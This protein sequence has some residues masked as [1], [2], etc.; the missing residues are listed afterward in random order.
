MISGSNRSIA[1]LIQKLT[2]VLSNID[3]S[4]NTGLSAQRK[5]WLQR[6]AGDLNANDQIC[7]DHGVVD[8]RERKAEALGPSSPH[9]HTSPSERGIGVGSADM[10]A[11]IRVA[12]QAL[13][14]CT[15][16]LSCYSGGTCIHSLATPVSE[17]E[18]YSC[19]SLSTDS[20]RSHLSSR[21]GPGG[22]RYA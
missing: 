1:E 4:E 13:H 3:I 20:C 18:C 15:A 11:L 22:R 10:K 5:R 14:S 2:R 12:F 17:F 16:N 8:M 9:V 7:V 21:G 19:P 6:R